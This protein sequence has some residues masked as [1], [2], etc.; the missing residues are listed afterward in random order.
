MKIPRPEPPETGY[1]PSSPCWVSID[2]EMFQRLRFLL[3]LFLRFFVPHHPRHGS[4]DE[5]LCLPFGETDVFPDLAER[6]LPGFDQ[7]IDC[8]CRNAENTSDVFGGE[9][10]VHHGRGAPPDFGGGLVAL[11]EGLPLG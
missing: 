1:K 9:E 6:K 3:R 8:L 2:A 11:P 10:M 5:R 7:G 4:I